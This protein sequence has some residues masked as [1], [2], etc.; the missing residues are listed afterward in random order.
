MSTNYLAIGNITKLFAALFSEFLYVTLYEEIS[1][2]FL[3]DL[4]DCVIV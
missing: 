2:T 3:S 1:C 4:F